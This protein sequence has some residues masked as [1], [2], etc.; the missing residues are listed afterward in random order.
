MTLT[1]Y[2]DIGHWTLVILN[3]Y[4]DIGQQTIINIFVPSTVATIITNLQM[5]VHLSQILY[6][7]KI[8]IK[9][10]LYYSSKTTLLMVTGNMA[11]GD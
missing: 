11:I 4:L 7:A 5:Q 3:F 9:G 8:K 2:L 6:K 1:F 10:I